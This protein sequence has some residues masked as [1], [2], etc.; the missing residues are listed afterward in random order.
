M[1]TQRNGFVPILVI[2][3]FAVTVV[4]IVGGWYYIKKFSSPPV[5]KH[6]VV[7]DEFSDTQSWKTYG[8]MIF[9]LKYPDNWKL[10]EPLSFATG[11]VFET[12][13]GLYID[14]KALYKDVISTE[15]I[16]K[17]S[18]SKYD[19]SVDG[20]TGTMFIQNDNSATLFVTKGLYKYMFVS[21]ISDDRLKKVLA[22]FKFIK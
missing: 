17:S 1:F 19:F 15:S 9:E 6:N 22:T 20:Q 8:N 13:D 18:K 12:N 4:A 2:V 3:T 16:E 7:A 5:G 10:V 21:S 14:I 11:A